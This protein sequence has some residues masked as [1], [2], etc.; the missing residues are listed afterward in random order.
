MEDLKKAFENLGVACA[1]AYSALKDFFERLCD[2]LAP[3]VK[4]YAAPNSR[5]KHLALH[6][7]K[8]R[9]RK[10]NMKRLLKTLAERD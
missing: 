9:V 5:I 7:K 2:A 10:K 8:K 1:A 6:S 4:I 3:A